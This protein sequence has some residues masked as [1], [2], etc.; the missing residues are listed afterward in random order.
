MDLGVMLFEGDL[1]KTAGGQNGDL[2]PMKLTEQRRFA[3]L[4]EHPRK[5][6]TRY[7]VYYTKSRS[8][9]HA[10][11]GFVEIGPETRVRLG[12]RDGEDA[13]QDTTTLRIITPDRVLF[14]RADD[15]A[16]A[17]AWLRELRA[18]TATFTGTR[19]GS[20]AAEQ[21]PARA[22]AKAT[23]KAVAAAGPKWQQSPLE[24]Q[25]QQT[26]G[27]GRDGG[28]AGSSVGGGGV[29]NTAALT[30]SVGT[31]TSITSHSH[32]SSAPTSPP[33]SASP[34]ASVSVQQEEP[35]LASAGEEY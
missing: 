12:W 21:P 26:S 22:K 24:A 34:A 16:S 35:G 32:T 30:T 6:S 7:V 1:F 5:A 33:D 20:A 28:D 8:T 17:Q 10:P 3:R 19:R 31:A 18:V 27:G 29:A 23:A 25:V 13:N 4:V 11:K 9:C 14:L 2:N 15:A